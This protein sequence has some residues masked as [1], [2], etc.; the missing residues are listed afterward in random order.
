MKFFPLT[1]LLW[2]FKVSQNSVMT[3]CGGGMHFEKAVMKNP[4]KARFSVKTES[5]CL[6]QNSF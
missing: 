1:S 4:E 3:S 2:T 6:R 5:D